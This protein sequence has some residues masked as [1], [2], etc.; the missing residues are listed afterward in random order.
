MT[1]AGER[2]RRHRDRIHG[3]EHAGD[4]LGGTRGQAGTARDRGHAALL[5][6][7]GADVELCD[8]ARRKGPQVVWI[9]HVEQRRREL[10]VVV[11]EPLGDAR[12]EQ[13]ERL[14]HVL[15][16]R[17]GAGVAAE[18]QAARDFRIAFCEI[19][20]VAAQVSQFR[21]VIR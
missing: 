12:I 2:Q 19:A 15:D 16:V 20:Q 21:L 3:A 10:R 17:I 5:A 4:A 8:R 9:E 6:G 11:V 7:C 18:Q 14:D 1:E 13:R